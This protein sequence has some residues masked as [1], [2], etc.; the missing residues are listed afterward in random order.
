MPDPARARHI[1]RRVVVTGGASGIGFATARRFVDEGARTVVLDRDVAGL[2]RAASEVPGLAGTVAADVADAADVDAAFAR[3]DEQLGGVDVLVANAGISVRR[4]FLEIEPEQWARV[5]GVNLTG[6]FLCARAAVRRMAAQRSGVVLFTSS[7][8]GLDGHPFYA[9][10]NASKAGI[11]LLMKTIALEHAPWL[12]ANAVCPGYVLTPMQQ[13]EY[14]P[15]MLEAVNATIPL[16]R[17]A[18]PEEVAA[19]FAFL[20]SDEAAYVTGQCISIDGGE[21]A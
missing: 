9:D 16:R 3:I 17:H 21:T 13:A 7:T 10:Y 14:T 11:N 20:A 8:N 5:I 2:E 4:P 15:E 6:A 12:R 19:L 1:G 18:R